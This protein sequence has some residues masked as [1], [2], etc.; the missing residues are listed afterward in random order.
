MQLTVHPL[1]SFMPFSTDAA[2]SSEAV[3][4]SLTPAGL[5][6]I[7]SAGEL[8]QPIQA[9]TYVWCRDSSTLEKELWSFDEFVRTNAWKWLDPGPWSNEH[10]GEVDRVKERS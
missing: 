3:E 7:P 5:P 2:A 8:G 1:G 10:Y 9:E 6:T 4:D